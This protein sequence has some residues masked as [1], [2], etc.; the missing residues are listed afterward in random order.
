[1]DFL[2]QYQSYQLQYKVKHLALYHALRDAIVSGLLPYLF[3]LPSSRELASLYLLSRGTINQVYEML[4][5]E[6]FVTTQLGSGTFVA[7]QQ[8]NKPNVRDESSEIRL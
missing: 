3:K 4:A 6:G 2:I 5:A 8:Q 1:M 7:F